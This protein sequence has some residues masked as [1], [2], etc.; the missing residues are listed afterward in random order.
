MCDRKKEVL[1]MRNSQRHISPILPVLAVVAVFALGA[2]G[3]GQPEPTPTMSVDAIYT[4][5]FQTLSAQQ[6]TQLA[7]TPP[8]S[9]PSQTPFAT[10]PPPTALTT[11]LPSGSATSSSGGGVQTCD[12]SIFAADVTIPDGTVMSPGQTFVKSWKLMNNGTCPWSTA[13]KLVFVIG[14]AMGGTSVPVPIAV[15]AGQQGQISVS[16]TA[17]VTAGDYTGQWQLANAQGQRFGNIVTVV[18]KV[19]GSGGATDTSG[20]PAT[21]TTS[22][23]P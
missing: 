2:C 18:I 22:P 13:Y 5:A 1:S 17:P 20:A 9:T 4:A 23:T 19:S 8:T 14:D 15:P 12:N 16:L 6:A 7:L 11:S 3:L 21:P 10:L